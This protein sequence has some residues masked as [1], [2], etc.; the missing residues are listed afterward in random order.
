MGLEVFGADA[1]GAV[2]VGIVGVQPR[3][4]LAPCLAET[5]MGCIRGS[6]VHAGQVAEL[7]FVTAQH[8]LGSVGRTAIHHDVLDPRVVL[9]ENAG[10]GFGKISPHVVGGRDDADE[11]ELRGHLRLCSLYRIVPNRQFGTAQWPV[12]VSTDTLSVCFAH[13]A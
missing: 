8:F 1:H 3:E 11:W 9:G 2:E 13:E 6:L 4:D 7:S 5:A 10:D 12:P